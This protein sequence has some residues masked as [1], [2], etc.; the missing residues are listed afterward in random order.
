MEGRYDNTRQLLMH[1]VV[2]S[3]SPKILSLEKVITN[4]FHIYTMVRKLEGNLGKYRKGESE[5]LKPD[6][7]VHP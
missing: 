6:V 2:S 1:T 5:M 4:N 3:L 7:G